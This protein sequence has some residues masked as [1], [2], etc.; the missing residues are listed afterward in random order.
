[1]H[2]KILDLLFLYIVQTVKTFARCNDVLFIYKSKHFVSTY[3]ERYAKAFILAEIIVLL[4]I[5]NLYVAYIMIN[6]TLYAGFV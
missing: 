3:T 1:M 4:R 2:V 6:L 5:I